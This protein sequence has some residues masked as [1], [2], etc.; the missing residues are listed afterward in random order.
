MER[1]PQ[2]GFITKQFPEGGGG[3]VDLVVEGTLSEG[4]V[5]V[6]LEG[7]AVTELVTEVGLLRDAAVAASWLGPTIAS[8][9]AL[10][11][12]VIEALLIPTSTR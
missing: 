5:D 10:I 12:R 1:F 9:L 4:I 8:D 7:H 2:L 3:C 11:R 6:H